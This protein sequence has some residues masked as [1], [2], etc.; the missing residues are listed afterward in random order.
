MII[1]DPRIF[2]LRSIVIVSVLKI[3]AS[4]LSADPT[5]PPAREADKS[6]SWDVGHGVKM[7]FVLIQPGSF[8]MGSAVDG[9]DQPVHKVTLTKPFYMGQYEVT[10]AQWKLLTCP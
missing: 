5:V 3:I 9:H 4:P 6:L 10:Q 7:A 1:K 2:V 8:M